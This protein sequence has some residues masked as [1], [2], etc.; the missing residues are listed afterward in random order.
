MAGQVLGTHF[1]MTNLAHV[2]Q[3]WTKMDS[4]NVGYRKGVPPLAH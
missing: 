2:E 4:L 3:R 1:G